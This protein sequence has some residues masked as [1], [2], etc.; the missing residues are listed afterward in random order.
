MEHIFNPTPRKKQRRR[1]PT[2]DPKGF[3][4]LTEYPDAC[5]VN[6]CKT[7]K[8]AAYSASLYPGAGKKTHIISISALLKWHNSG[9]GELERLF[10]LE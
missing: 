1:K 4:V 2:S 9:V 5:L 7:D 8:G 6:W 10:E 3:L